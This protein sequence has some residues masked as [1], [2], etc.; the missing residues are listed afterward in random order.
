MLTRGKLAEASGVGAETIRFYERRGILPKP[1]RSLSGYRIYP[2]DMSKQV[3]FIKRAQGLGFTLNEIQNLLKLRI[4]PN[5]S[6][7]RI[8]E[9]AVLKHAIVRQKIKDLKAI[10]QVLSKLIHD[11]DAKANIKACPILNALEEEEA[12]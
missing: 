5:A 4:N 11:C 1:K 7:A 12:K 6:C 8:K 2:E 3:R 10:D 9:K